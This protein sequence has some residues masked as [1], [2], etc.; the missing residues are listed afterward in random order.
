M[1]DLVEK[2]LTIRL[3]VCA[4]CLQVAVQ[5]IIT[6]FGDI[7]FG[8]SGLTLD[9]WLWC[10][11]LGSTELVVGQLLLLIPVDKLPHFSCR[12]KGGERG[13]RGGREGRGGEGRGEGR[14]GER[15]CCDAF[16]TPP[17]LQRRSLWRTNQTVS[18]TTTNVL[19][20]SGSSRSPDCGHRYASISRG[21]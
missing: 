4:I 3:Y 20:T 18:M 19:A 2:C 13:E 8:T 16:V 6:Q 1:A 5:I 14:R 21:A 12:R 10:I 11:F 9:L 7:V 15:F 17:Q